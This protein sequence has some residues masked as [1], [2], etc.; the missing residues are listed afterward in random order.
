MANTTPGQQDA[1]FLPPLRIALHF[2]YCCI[3]VV[4][5]EISPEII[6]KLNLGLFDI[7]ESLIFF[8]KHIFNW[9]AIIKYEIRSQ[10]LY[11]VISPG[12]FCHPCN[13]C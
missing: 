6:D 8:C 11:H 1:S 10:S 12:Q 7:E 13:T 3:I 5:K 9:V 2:S 4:V